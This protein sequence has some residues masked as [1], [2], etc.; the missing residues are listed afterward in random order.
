MSYDIWC[1]YS[2]NLE[3]RFKRNFED[4]PLLIAQVAKMRGAIPKMHIRGHGLECQINHSFYYKNYS[5]MTCGE[6]IESSWSEQNHAAN[7]TKE[8]NEGH[9][10]NTLDDFN[11]YWNWC[12]VIQLG[13][14]STH[15]L[16]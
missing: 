7:S 10:H 16:T 15:N 5:G 4:Q 2:K 13:V 12:K 8:L 11:G 9:R 1:Q 6:G 3:D 14:S